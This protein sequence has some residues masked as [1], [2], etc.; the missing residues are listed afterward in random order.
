VT[1]GNELTVPA[2]LMSDLLDGVKDNIRVMV[3]AGKATHVD[4]GDYRVRVQHNSSVFV[5]VVKE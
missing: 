2:A 3:L 4:V 1:K 5:D